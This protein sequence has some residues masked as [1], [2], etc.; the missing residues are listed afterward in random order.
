MRGFGIA[1]G[2]DKSRTNGWYLSVAQDDG[3]RPKQYFADSK[4]RDRAYNAKVVE[5]RSV[6][7]GA[8]SEVS[9]ADR[10]ALAEMRRLAEP[11][12]FPILD[13]FQRGLA[14]LGGNVA[15]SNLTVGQAETTFRSEQEARHTDGKISAVRLKEVRGALR[16][17][18][19]IAGRMPLS[20][21][22]RSSVKAYLTS[23]GVAPQTRL[24][25][26]R[27]LSFFFRWCLNEGMILRNPVPEQ[28]G[29]S[30]IPTVFDNA[31]VAAL[32]DLAW[33][34]NAGLVP[35][36]AVQWFAGLRP[37]ASHHLRWEDVDFERRRLLI[38][39]HTN[40]L[41]QPDIVQDL[42]LT[43]FGLLA[44]FRQLSGTL[45]PA[46]HVKQ[47]QK[48]HHAFGYGGPN[49]AH[50]PEDV[51]RHTFASN[52]YSLYENDSKRVEAVLLHSTS[53][54]LRKHYLL[55]NI[56]AEA[57]AEYFARHLPSA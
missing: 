25:H 16:R 2:F 11:T 57:A 43:V 28:E 30:R 6:G 1:K 21:C 42:P 34:T 18:T 54:M 14:Q 13:I 37:G 15:L 41:R 55:K 56:P 38:Q 33:A 12:G 31:K 48:L 27:I 50:W 35:M 19:G 39:P 20:A 5:I 9:V 47:V 51:A 32:F 36:L 53:A 40:K 7:V 10:H 29:V 46:G 49:A 22:S 52:L 24:N 8:A 23:L 44:P 17:Y 3:R 26:A 4:A 45:A